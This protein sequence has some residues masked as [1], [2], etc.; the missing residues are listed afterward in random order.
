MMG[1]RNQTGAALAAALMLLDHIGAIFFP[2][3]MLPRVLGR[4]SF[5][6]FAFGIAQGV[7]HTAD[8]RRYLM[9]ILL[10]AVI[11]Q[12][13]YYLAFWETKPNPLFTLAL[14]AVVLQLWRSEG[15]QRACAIALLAAAWWYPGSYGWYGVATIFVYGFYYVRPT[16]AFYGQ[17]A[18][19]CEYALIW[20]LFPQVFSLLAFPLAG[21]EWKRSITL[22]RYFLYAFYPLHLLVLIG[23]RELLR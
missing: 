7:E 23:V 13:I 5:P 2:Y 3:S 12:P 8:F 1:K 17:V 11:S 14:G 15:W 22:P 9:R 20:S 19:Q 10:A 16:L 21:R 4:L 6:L 18:L